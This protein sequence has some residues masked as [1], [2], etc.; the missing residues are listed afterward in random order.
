MIMDAVKEAKNIAFDRVG[1]GEKVLLIS[2]FPQT[3]QSWNQIV[4]LLSAKFQTIAA[5]LPSFGD[6]AMLEVPATTEKCGQNISRIR[7][8]HWLAAPCRRPRFWRL[9]R[10]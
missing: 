1:S 5:D 2:G 10:L 9:G 3:R 6:S 7:F 4:P 8:D